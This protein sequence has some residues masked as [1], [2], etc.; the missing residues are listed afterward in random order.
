MIGVDGDALTIGSQPQDGFMVYEFCRLQYHAQIFLLPFNGKEPMI[1]PYYPH[2]S[3]SYCF[4]LTKSLMF[5]EG[6]THSLDT[7]RIERYY[8]QFPIIRWFMIYELGR[9]KVEFIDIVTISKYTQF[10]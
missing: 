10:L 4:F 1:N 3:V 7:T 9:F 6:K 2:L 5:K 8:Y